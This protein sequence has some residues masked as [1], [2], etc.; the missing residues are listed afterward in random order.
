[1]MVID[2]IR[3]GCIKGIKIMLS[4]LKIVIPVYAGVVI[5]KHIGLIA[6]TQK[7][8]EPFM[9]LFGLPGKAVVPIVS[10]MFLDEYAIIAAMKAVGITGFS[11]TVVAVIGLAAHSFP[12]EGAIYKKLGLSVIGFTSYRIFLAI[13]MG[14][15]V[16]LIGRVVF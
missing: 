7:L 1:M 10:G 15:L 9:K 12:V 6:L 5:I 3:I 16:S 14:L 11:I 8:F 2:A 13:V 4:L